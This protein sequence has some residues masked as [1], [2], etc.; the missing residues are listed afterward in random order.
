MDLGR[1]FLWLVVAGEEVGD[2]LGEAPVV[3]IQDLAL[4]IVAAVLVDGDGL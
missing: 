3:D 4:G 2:V 1:V